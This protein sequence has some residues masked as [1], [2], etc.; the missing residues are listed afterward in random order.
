[1]QNLPF[2]SGG[3]RRSSSKEEWDS[4]RS[5]SLISGSSIYPALRAPE[6]HMRF[7]KSSEVSDISQDGEPG[8]FNSLL[9]DHGA[10]HP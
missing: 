4:C 9:D 7:Q 2:G 10:G 3:G 8:L 1:M 6:R 5:P